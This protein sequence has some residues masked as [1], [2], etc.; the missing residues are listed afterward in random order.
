M[1]TL[2]FTRLFTRGLHA[3]IRNHDQISFATPQDAMTWKAAIA[4][5]KRLP[6]II[7]DASFQRY[8]R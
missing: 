3:G 5:N 1:A 4:R 2:Y 7:V 6:W 8:T